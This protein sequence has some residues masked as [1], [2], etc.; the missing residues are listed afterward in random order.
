MKRILITL[1]ISVVCMLP[2]ASVLAVDV[3]NNSMQT[4]TLDNPLGTNVN[5]DNAVPALVGVIIRGA[6]GVVGSLV[7]LMVVWGGFTWLTAAG[8]PEKVKLG[9]NTMMWA[10]IGLVVIFS[11]YFALDFV[12]KAIAGKI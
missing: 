2:A 8:N 1:L 3:P 11:S 12:L 9:S 7:L 4:V 6:L 10:V 5:S